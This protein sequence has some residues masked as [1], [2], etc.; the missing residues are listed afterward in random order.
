MNAAQFA[1]WMPVRL[2][3]EGDHPMV[4]WCY[5]GA[6]RF[7]EPFFADTIEKR[8]YTPFNLLFRKQTSIDV[9]AELEQVAP[10]VPPSGFIFHM[11][12]CGSTLVSQMLAALPQNIVI[13]EAIPIDMALRSNFFHPEVTDE[14]RVKWLRGIVSALAR[15]RAGKE[16]Y[17]FCKLDCWH[18]LEL[19]LIERAF[20]GVPWIFLYRNPVEVIVSHHGQR[21]TQMVP[22]MLAPNWLGLDAPDLTAVSLDDYAA[23][24]LVRLCEAALQFRD[25][26][27]LFVNYRQLPD[28]VWSRIAE[29]FRIE[30]SPADI[31]RMREVAQFHAKSPWERFGE[32]TTT[33]N[34]AA[35]DWMRELAAQYLD[36]LY[37]KLESHVS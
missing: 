8:F 19:P 3:W 34:R 22:G 32:D 26:S 31:E 28:A 21:G 15:P 35:A 2:Y 20:P 1:D 18:I 11:S 23:R 25:A 37:A 10:G 29:H 7:T 30:F 6:S 9:L 27:S 33:K 16:K 12:R 4:D 13:S 14:Q 24:V 5:L 17:F 36:P